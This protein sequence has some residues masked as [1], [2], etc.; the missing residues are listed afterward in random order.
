MLTAWAP[1]GGLT[2][3]ERIAAWE[4]KNLR[5]GRYCGSAL[6]CDGFTYDRGEYVP[7]DKR[8]SAMLEHEW[9]LKVAEAWKKRAR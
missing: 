9:A 5:N 1:A 8:H 4:R 6:R 7:V 3:S 2:V